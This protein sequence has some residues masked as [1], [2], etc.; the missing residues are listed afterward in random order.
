MPEVLAA[1]EI[2]SQAASVSEALASFLSPVEA[3]VTAFAAASPS[4]ADFDI[5]VVLSLTTADVRAAGA[6]ATDTL[7]RLTLD[8]LQLLLDAGYASHEPLFVDDI[9]PPMPV[10]RSHRQ[11]DDIA[12]INSDAGT[13][14]DRLTPEQFIE[15]WIPRRPKASNNFEHFGLNQ[16]SP[17]DALRQIHIE[18]QP[19]SL[20]NLIVVDLDDEQPEWALK[21]L[22]EEDESLPEPSFTIINRA[23]GH[24][25]VGWFI[26]DAVGSEKGLA[27]L[28]DIREKM[29]IR[30]RGDRAYHGVTMRNPLHQNHLTVWGTNHRYSLKEL[31]E[32]VKEIVPTKSAKVKRKLAEASGRNDVI[33]ILVSEWAYRNRRH[34]RNDD[35]DAW[36]DEVLATAFAFSD[37]QFPGNGLPASELATISKGVAKWVWKHEEFS[38]AGFA[39]LQAARAALA[40]QVIASRIKYVQALLMRDAGMTGAEIGDA[41][42]YADKDSTNR[43]LRVARK[44][45]EDKP[46]E[47]RAIISEPFQPSK[48]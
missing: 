16:M 13:A 39:R 46:F 27:W 34:Y 23:S 12:R 10:I 35:F 40:P 18:T 14:T 42:G 48:F 47:Y 7:A 45:R 33:H 8:D 32:Y 43:M 37:E 38:A 15:W 30:L 17:E 44:W 25:H 28:K 24:A 1:G 36:H 11:L 6:A 20:R 41:L 22:V 9:V 26:E 3:T 21:A 5:A 2:A 19:P 31:N 4:A 29:T